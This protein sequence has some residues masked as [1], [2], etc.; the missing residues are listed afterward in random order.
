LCV[1]CFVDVHA[2]FGAESIGISES[3]RDQGLR[4]STI[5]LMVGVLRLSA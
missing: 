1:P 3:V 2:K 4:E 5:V